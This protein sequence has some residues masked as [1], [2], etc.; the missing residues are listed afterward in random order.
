MTGLGT[1]RTIL[2]TQTAKPAIGQID[3]NLRTKLAFRADGKKVTKDQHPDYQ[4]RIDQRLA[5]V[6]V[7]G[8][9]FRVQPTQIENRINPAHQMIGWNDI[10]KTESVE[11]TILRTL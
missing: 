9:Q 7:I 5:R 10:I 4:L 11:K 2:N 8:L 3:L 6:A 1:I